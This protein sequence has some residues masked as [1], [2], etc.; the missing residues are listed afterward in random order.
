MGYTKLFNEILASTIWQ[1]PDHVRLVWI[2]MLAMK[3]DRHEVMASIPGLAKNANVT[4]EH[5]ENAIKELSS[6]DPYSRSQDFEG[7]RIEAIRGGWHILNGEYYRQKR[8]EEDN[9]EYMRE[10]MRKYRSVKP[11]VKQSKEMLN[12]LKNVKPVN[13]T[14]QN[15]TEKNIINK[16]N[17]LIP[18]KGDDFEFW[19]KYPSRNGVKP[20]KQKA[21]KEWQKLKPEEKEKAMLSIEAQKEHFNR[22]K[23]AMVFVAEFPDAFRWIRDKKFNDEIQKTP[24]NGSGSTIDPSAEDWS[25]I[26]EHIKRYGSQTKMVGLS[27]RGRAALL[28]IG[29]LSTVGQSDSFKLPFLKK[30]FKDAYL[31]S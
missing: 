22:C 1:A 14:E 30:D 19:K 2:T 28:K 29:G 7:R 27:D 5:C 24:L 11:D 17:P 10:Y 8:S 4:I 9:R 13:T 26:I 23:N 3:D 25:R 12:V 31:V 6:P 15:T 16:E 20:N 21:L 18:L